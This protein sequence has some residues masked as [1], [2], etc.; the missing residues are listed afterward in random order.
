MPPWTGFQGSCYMFFTD[1]KR[2]LLAEEH[3]QSLST[4]ARECHLAS[5]TSAAESNFVRDYVKKVWPEWK[6]VDPPDLWI[7]YDD[8]QKEGTWK[9]IDGQKST[10]YAPWRPSQPDN[11][12]NEDCATLWLSTG[13]WNDV[14]CD[15]EETTKNPFICEIPQRAPLSQMK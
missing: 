2:Y 9:W 10:S 4:S 12:Y 15:S 14:S 1:K 5:I 8:K 7:G 11:W 3:C 13:E 6:T